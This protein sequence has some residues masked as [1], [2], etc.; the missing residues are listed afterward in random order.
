MLARLAQRFLTN[1]V[2]LNHISTKRGRHVAPF[3][4]QDQRPIIVPD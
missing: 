1:L 2:S 3:V 4:E